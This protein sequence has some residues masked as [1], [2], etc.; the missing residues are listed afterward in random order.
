M[1]VTAERLAAQ[2]GVTRNDQDEYACQSHLKAAAAI[3]RGAFAEEIVPLELKKG[4]ET[5]LFS[6]D[7]P[8]RKD[9]SIEKMAKL[10]TVFQENGTVT[11]GNACPMNDAAAATW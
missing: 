6:E 11:A 7:E 9:I 10:A 4:R 5:I 2:Y 3:E 1:G 8:V